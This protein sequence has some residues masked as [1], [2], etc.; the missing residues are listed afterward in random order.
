MLMLTFNVILGYHARA[1]YSDTSYDFFFLVFFFSK[2]DRSTQYQERHST[3]NDEKKGMA[4]VYVGIRTENSRASL[5]AA[6]KQCG[7]RIKSAGTLR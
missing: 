2:S 4:L 6:A 3:L 1:S 7:V 5:K